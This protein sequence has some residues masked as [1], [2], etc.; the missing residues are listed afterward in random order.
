MQHEDNL[1]TSPIVKY[2]CQF[3]SLGED[4]SGCGRKLLFIHFKQFA[5]IYGQYRFYNAEE[6]KI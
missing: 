4:Y 3:N 5:L 6:K 1:S 2:V